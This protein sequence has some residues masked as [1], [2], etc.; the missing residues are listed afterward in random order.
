MHWYLQHGM[1]L[2]V[3]YQLLEYEQG[4]HFSLFPEEAIND[5]PEVEKYPLKKPD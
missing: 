3:V 5:T 4:K 1:K 2:T